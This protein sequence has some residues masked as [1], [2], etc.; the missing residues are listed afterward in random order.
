[1]GRVP[2]YFGVTNQPGPVSDGSLLDPARFKEL[3]DRALP[4]V[5]GYFFKR[6]GG[7]EALAA[8]LTQETFVSAIRS[9]KRGA[10]VEM[11]MPWL[12]SIARRRLVDHLRSSSRKA[13]PSG[14]H[15]SGSADITTS[16]AE[17]RLTEALQA[18][19]PNHRL[20]L[21]LR[22]VDDL[23]VADVAKEI[24]R[25]VRATESMLARARTALN[26]AYQA[27]DDV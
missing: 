25:S 13:A 17:V 3:Y 16:S 12:M 5:Y 24:G 27:V 8:D 10:S 15:A 14:P 20:V 22:Y 7:S 6:V 1:M 11:P 26:T 9:L 18:I 19:S 4:V 2:T 23:Q 21:I